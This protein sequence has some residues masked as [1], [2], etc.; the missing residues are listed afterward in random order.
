MFIFDSDS[1]I[2]AYRDDFPP[3]GKHS[4]FWN[5]FDNVVNNDGI[6]IPEKVFE[7]LNRKTD[8]LGKFLKKY[9][10]LKPEPTEKCL[11]ILPK[12]LSTYGEL[13]EV[14]LERLEKKADPYLIS[15]AIVLQGTVVSCEVSS[16][17][18][19]GLNKKIP[20]ICDVLHVSFESYP[21]FLWRLRGLYPG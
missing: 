14:D 20:D 4:D 6:V 10:N 19:I 17:N 12:V 3:E 1:L 13:S 2:R 16:P 18:R 7:E 11:S 9:Q 8:G 21:R 15:H 5:W